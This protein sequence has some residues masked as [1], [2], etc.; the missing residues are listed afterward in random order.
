MVTHNTLD[1]L[2]LNGTGGL[3]KPVTYY[4]NIEYLILIDGFDIIGSVII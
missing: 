2:L 3:Q 4:Y 1:A